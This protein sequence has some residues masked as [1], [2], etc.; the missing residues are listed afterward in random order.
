M[1]DNSS[2]VTESVS[3][4]GSDLRARVDAI[5]TNR[6]LDPYA[7]R[8]HEYA[9][10]I[11]DG[12]RGDALRGEWFGHPLHPGLTDVPLG[13]WLAAGVLDLVGGRTSRRAAQRLV[14]VGLLM[15]PVTVATGLADYSTIDSPRS[16][17]VGLVHAAGNSVVAGCYF[18]SW[19]SRRRG[20]HFRGV[21]WGL[22]GGALG[23]VTAY[24]GGHLAFA[25]DAGREQEPF[26]LGRA[27]MPPV[28][29]SPQDLP[30]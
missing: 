15:V 9:R 6:G 4:A 12:S 8:L 13:C 7:R 10:R 14:G 18:C 5:E 24:L 28:A 21:L 11:A 27:E 1:H 23:S 17:R 20:R 3:R 22:A 19:R 30:A 26:D 16:Q 29:V 2:Q 25:G